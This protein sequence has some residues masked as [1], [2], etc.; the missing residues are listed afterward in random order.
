MALKLR[1]IEDNYYEVE[2][3]FVEKLREYPRLMESK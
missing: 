2:D 1:Y 3:W